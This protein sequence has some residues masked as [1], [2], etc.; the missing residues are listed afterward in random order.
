MAKRLSRLLL[1]CLILLGSPYPVQSQEGSEDTYSI[2]LVQTA[3]EDKEIIEVEGRKVLAETYQVKKGDHLWQLLRERGL[4][5]KRN[6]SEILALLKKLN[7]SLSNLD[8]VYPGQEIIIPLTVTPVN[9]GSRTSPKL[10]P[11]TPISLEDLKDLP[12][13]NYTVRPGDSL[14]KVIKRR[15]NIPRRQL[16]NEYLDL[17]KRL[18][19]SIRD[20]NR[21]YPNQ[22]LRLPVYSPQV[23]RS[24]VPSRPPETKKPPEI[25][26]ESTRED[27]SQLALQLGAVFRE[28]GEE[29][30]DSG[31]H[32][33]P[34]KSGGQ[35]ELNAASFPIINLANGHRVILDLNR[36]LPSRMAQVIESN[37]KNYKVLS[38]PSGESLRGALEK[39]LPFCGY[40]EVK[41]GG[42]P[43]EIGGD[44][45][46]RVTADWIIKT[47]AGS[48]GEAAQIIALALLDDQ[49]PKVPLEVKRY[50]KGLGIRYVEYP[51]E[52]A[53]SAGEE[54]LPP[55]ETLP[56][57]DTPGDL[58][59]SLLEL[60][61]HSYSRDLEIPVYQ[62][63]GTDFNVKIKADFFLNIAGKDSIV[64]LSDLGGEILTLLK[65]HGFSVLSLHD[66]KDPGALVSK[67]LAFLGTAFDSSPHTFLTAERTDR[68]NIQITVPGITFLGQSGERILATP[69]NLPGDITD[70][71]RKKGYRVLRLPRF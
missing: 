58:V 59:A 17:V 3:E 69:V 55:Q 24:P 4:L 32:F 40:T 46:V 52:E 9:A 21:I 60:T 22:K 26:K 12:L 16:Y 48:N 67:T 2:S 37:W 5:E 7:T 25:Q 38:L 68:R 36:E 39:I 51:S 18:N 31:Q 62:D 50:L 29:W 20:L 44:L 54:S 64:D 66:E 63:K 42:E 10:P 53:A 35:V 70:F 28:M 56:G 45:P 13:E 47:G 71:L 23:V 33:I 6:L 41:E 65:D 8:M 11:E 27:Y 49:T 30:V 19:P 1:I 57:G 14:I 15:Y 34:L 61:G 43:L